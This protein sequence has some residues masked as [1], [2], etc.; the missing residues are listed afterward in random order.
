MV[1][2]IRPFVAGRRIA[3]FR[4]CACR[5]KPIL[6]TPALPQAA[7]RAA[8]RTVTS[9][10]RRAKRIV[11]G[12]DSGEAFVIEPRMTGL[13]LLGDPPTRGHLRLEAWQVA[14]RVLRELS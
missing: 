2:G 13:M 1:R 3:L 5:C 12:L 4:K 6:L 9:V 11:L 14:A 8:G 10:F 7:R